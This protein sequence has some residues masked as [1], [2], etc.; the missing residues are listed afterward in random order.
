MKVLVTGGA[1]FIGSH[2]VEHALRAGH[3]V[4]VLDDLSTGKRANVPSQ[5]RLFVADLR[6]REAVL[7]V[8][9]AVRPQ[10]VSHHA[11]QSSVAISMRDPHLDASINILGGINLLDAC[12]A[13]GVQR[14]VFASTGGAMYGNVPEGKRAS[15]ETRPAPISPYAISKLALE[16]LLAV[17]RAQHR[18]ESN[19]LRYSNVY[20]PRQ[21]PHGEAGLVAIFSG[22]LLRSQ[23][24]RINARKVSGDAGCVRDYVFVD[25]VARANIAA[26]EGRLQERLINIATGQP[27]STREL[28][29]Q[30]A[31]IA[32]PQI[33]PD[34]DDGPP[35][36]GDVEY[37]VLDNTRFRLA[38]G[39]PVPLEHGLR[40]TYEWFRNAAEQDSNLD[41]RHEH[42]LG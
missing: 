31:L 6:D 36:P 7:R 17:Y 15:E 26:L 25:D 32:R 37:T 3:L 34:D 16:Q 27:T 1:G 11:A 30:L 29:T 35:R 33:M 2:V 10:A 40:K 42:A 12:V 23:R 24:L 28:A 18:L 22:L 8:L 38:F 41:A 5:A 13:V 4:S 39:D 14:L 9:E 19:V 21:D 20:G